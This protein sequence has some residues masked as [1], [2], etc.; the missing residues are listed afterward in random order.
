MSGKRLSTEEKESILKALRRNS[1]SFQSIAKEHSVSISTISRIAAEH[2]LSS[3]RKRT[4]AADVP[5]NSYD[6]VQRISALDRMLN[7][8]DKMVER[9]GLSTRQIKDLAGAAQSVFSTRRAEDIEPEGE[10]KEPEIIWDSTFASEDSPGIGYE[11]GSHIAKEME[12]LK[13][14]LERE[15]EDT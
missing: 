15:Y 6:R 8:I 11:K 14:E 12:K 7:S 3:P 10:K 13:R 4:S 2:G 1:K 5:E 9:G